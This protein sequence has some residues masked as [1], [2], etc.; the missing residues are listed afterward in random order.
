MSLGSL[1]LAKDYDIFEAQ[2]HCNSLGEVFLAMN[3]N[4]YGSLTVC[5]SYYLLFGFLSDYGYGLGSCE[6]LDDVLNTDR[7]YKF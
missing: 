7:P 6:V 5:L 2:N 4:Q 1:V 3:F